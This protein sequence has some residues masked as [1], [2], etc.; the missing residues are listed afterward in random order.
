[1]RMNYR[2]RNDTSIP[3]FAPRRAARFKEVLNNY[4]HHEYTR[5]KANSLAG[6]FVLIRV[7]SWLN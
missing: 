2:A 3:R 6:A 4:L 1:M 5:M 7:H